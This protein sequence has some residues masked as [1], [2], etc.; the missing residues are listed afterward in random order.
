MPTNWRRKSGSCDSSRAS[1]RRPKQRLRPSKTRLRPTWGKLRS[2][3]R[4]SIRSP[5]S[6]SP[7]PGWTARP[8][9]P[10]PL[11]WWN[12]SPRPP[13]PAASAWPER[14]N[15]PPGADRAARPGAGT[16]PI[17]PRQDSP[18]CPF[19]QM[20]V[21]VFTPFAHHPPPGGWCAF[22]CFRENPVGFPGFSPVSVNPL[23]FSRFLTP[24]RMRAWQVISQEPLSVPVL[25]CIPAY[26]PGGLLGTTPPS[27]ITPA[28]IYLP[29]SVPREAPTEAAIGGMWGRRPCARPCVCMCVCA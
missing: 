5:R 25:G 7:P 20:Q 19:G 13:P 17:G 6:P 11:S 9:E 12:A 4:E 24:P 1:S 29:P 27:R 21:A 26:H 23:R 14:A 8:S 16:L 28:V 22:F 18:I 2:C 15:T 10:P 3:E